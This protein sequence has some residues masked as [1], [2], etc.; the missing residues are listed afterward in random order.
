MSGRKVKQC[1]K[2]LDQIRYR[3]IDLHAL[4]QPEAA[5]KAE[6]AKP[7][8]RRSKNASPH[9]RASA[10]EPKTTSCAT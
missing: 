9:P 6:R 1:K 4:V 10:A 2:L 7:G 8:M 5:K 3:L